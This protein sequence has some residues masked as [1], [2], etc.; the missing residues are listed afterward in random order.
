MAFKFVANQLP[1]LLNLFM[2]IQ[3]QLKI[4]VVTM[5]AVVKILLADISCCKHFGKS[6]AFKLN[7]LNIASKNLFLN[8]LKLNNKL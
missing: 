6:F 7:N 2:E 1:N 3:Q 4:Q 8:E 5:V